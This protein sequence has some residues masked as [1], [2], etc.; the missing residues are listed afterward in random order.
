MQEDKLWT[1]IAN[2]LSGEASEED[3]LQL[4]Q[5]LQNNHALAYRLH[6]LA[7]FW[8]KP[9]CFTEYVPI[10]AIDDLMKKIQP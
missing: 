4:H 8:K 1:L 2:K 3:L 7:E 6:L 5:Y 10:K 9:A